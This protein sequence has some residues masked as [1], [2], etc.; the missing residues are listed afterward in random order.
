M[1]PG[2]QRNHGDQRLSKRRREQRACPSMW[3]EARDDGTDDSDGEHPEIHQVGGFVLTPDEPNG[4]V[5]PD[6]EKRCRKRNADRNS[7]RDTAHLPRYQL[8]R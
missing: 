2:N 6:E 8:K 1:H 4:K 3:P 5:H 7:V